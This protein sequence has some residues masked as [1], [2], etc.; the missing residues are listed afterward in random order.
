MFEL[1]FFIMFIGILFFTGLSMMTVFIALGVSIFVMFLMGMVGFIIKLLPWIIVI[2]IG[3]W[4]Y[5]NYIV[6][7][8]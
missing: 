2:A 6:S 7:A 5:K 1:L 4:V 8:R 3:V